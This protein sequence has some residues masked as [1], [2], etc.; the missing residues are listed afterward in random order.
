MPRISETRHVDT[1]AHICGYDGGDEDSP[2]CGAPATHHLI[3]F[4]QPHV[5]LT[6]CNAHTLTARALTGDW[7]PITSLCGMPATLWEFGEHQGDSRCVW[8][9]GEAIEAEHRQETAA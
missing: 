4:T 3:R 6:A 8:P 7:H 2:I 5:T 9:E 1:A